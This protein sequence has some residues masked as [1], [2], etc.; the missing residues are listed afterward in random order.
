MGLFFPNLL[1]IRPQRG[2]SPWQYAI[3]ILICAMAIGWVFFSP[4]YY[5][6]ALDREQIMIVVFCDTSVLDDPGL[7]ASVLYDEL[8]LTP[9]A[10]ALGL[11]QNRPPEW[12]K[13]Y[14]AQAARAIEIS[15]YSITLR[16]VRRGPISRLVFSA[17]GKIFKVDVPDRRLVKGAIYVHIHPL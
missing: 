4:R 15:P 2:R 5:A 3:L 1:K 6:W 9:I 10:K 16:N 17:R 14:F 13:A 12:V 8:A 11:Y 7:Q